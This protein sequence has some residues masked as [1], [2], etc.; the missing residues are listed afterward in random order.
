MVQKS[1]PNEISE[2]SIPNK[3]RKCKA[4][5]LYLNQLP[6]YDKK[7]DANIFWVGLSAVQFADGEEQIPLSPCTRSGSLIKRIEEPFESSI[8][9]YRTNIVKCLP[10]VNDRIRYPV[11]YEMEKCYPNFEYEVEKLRPSLI[12]LLGKQVGQFVLNK[13][14]KRISS[15]SDDFAYDTFKN[16]GIIYIPI[17][18]PSYILVYRRKDILGY[19]NG[20]QTIFDKSLQTAVSMH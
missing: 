9:F 4:C 13:F 8:S 5:G 14:S 2:L 18:H 19:I 17:H 16:D 3:G 11:T 6:A 12:F 7:K 15:L 10:L 1:T 20:I